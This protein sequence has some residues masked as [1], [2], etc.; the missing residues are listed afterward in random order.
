MPP[1]VA[2]ARSLVLHWSGGDYAS[3]FPAYHFCVFDPGAPAVAATADVAANARELHAGSTGY[4]AHV[5]GRNSF[6]IGLAVMCMRDARPDD[7]GPF[8]LIPVLVDALCLAAARIADA[9]ALPQAAITTHAEAAL[10]DGYFGSGD[11]QR[12]DIARLRPAPEAL[13]PAEAR[14]V[15]DALRAQIAGLRA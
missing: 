13:A 11:E 7:F 10:A 15:G 5:A 14:S 8:P 1:A 12:W 3:V 2:V 9:Y 4:A 6:A